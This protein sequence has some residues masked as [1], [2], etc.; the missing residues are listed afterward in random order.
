MF[1]NLFEM[2]KD[3]RMAAASDATKS[4]KHHE[5]RG[6][7]LRAIHKKIAQGS[8]YTKPHQNHRE[9]TRRRRQLDL[10]QLDYTASGQNIKGRKRLLREAAELG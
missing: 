4:L 1:H 3:V 8:R 5:V 2:L 6:T 7:K 10:G 9:T